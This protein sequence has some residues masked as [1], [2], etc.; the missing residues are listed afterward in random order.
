MMVDEKNAEIRNAMDELLRRYDWDFFITV[1]FNRDTTWEGA[2]ANLKHWHAA[3]DRNLLGGRW[4]KKTEQ[5]TFYFAFMEG[6]ETNRHW[7][8][9]ARVHDGKQDKLENTAAWIWKDIVKSGSMDVQR[10]ETAYD[11]SRA[12]GYAI[13]QLWADRNLEEFLVSTEFEGAT[14]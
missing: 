3:M 7:H 13:K 9:L 6:A 12:S 14:L 2:R 11:R 10:L 4:A 5:R 8:M 1:N